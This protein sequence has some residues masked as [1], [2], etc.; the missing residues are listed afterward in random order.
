MTLSGKEK[1]EHT[2]SV[3]ANDVLELYYKE[4]IDRINSIDVTI[5]SEEDKERINGVINNFRSYSSRHLYNFTNNKITSMVNLN[6]N[7][8]YIHILKLICNVF[9]ERL[10]ITNYAIDRIYNDKTISRLHEDDN[11][12][13]KAIKE[14]TISD[15]ML[16]WENAII[17]E[18]VST[19]EFVENSVRNRIR[20]YV[21]YDYDL[22]RL[23]GGE[24]Y[25][26]NKNIFIDKIL[27][28]RLDVLIRYE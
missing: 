11:F 12:Y 17:S 15:I 8:N 21:K 16:K 3:I 26:H 14:E 5:I 19:V 2:F 9:S 23:E 28:E 20:K 7:N 10:T 6:E 1:L 4:S 24:T 27:D 25:T 18:V 13:G 22:S